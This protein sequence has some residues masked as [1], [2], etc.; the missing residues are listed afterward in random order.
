MWRWPSHG[1]LWRTQGAS[2]A[3]GRRFLPVERAQFG[4]V[5]QHTQRGDRAHGVEGFELPDLL[6]EMRRAGQRALTFLLDCGQLLFQVGHEFLLLARDEGRHAVFDRLP[7]AH[8]LPFEMVAPLNQRPQFVTRWLAGWRRLGLQRHAVGSEHRGVEG[9]VFGA[10]P[11]CQGEV[12]DECGVEHADGLGGGVKRGHDALFVATGSFADDLHAGDGPDLFEEGGVAC[13]VV[14]QDVL[15]VLE[16][17]LE[18]GF[19]DVQ[20]C[21]DSRVFFIQGVQCVQGVRS[22]TCSYEHAA[23]G[24]VTAPSTVRVRTRRPGRLWLLDKRENVLE[25]CEHTRAAAFPPAGGKAASA[26]R[27]A[28]SQTRKM[29]TNIQE[30]AVGIVRLRLLSRTIP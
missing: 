5:A 15:D 26:S 9:I 14:I 11:L 13:G 16:V 7:G 6:L 19:G 12:T 24:G 8:Q 1:P 23:P 2:P 10:L 20:A 4:Q 21:I 27:L 22:P 30:G 28:F 18:G 25:G 29:K 17:E 3:K